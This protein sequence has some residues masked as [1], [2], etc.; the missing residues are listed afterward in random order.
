MSAIEQV[1]PRPAPAPS[2]SPFDTLA[3]DY[4]R[5]FT[6]SRIGSRMRQAVWPRLQARFR[7]GSRVLELNCGTGE[8]AVFLARNGVQVFA[9]DGSTAMAQA[10]QAKLERAGLTDLATAEALT[11]EQIVTRAELAEAEVQLSGLPFDGALSN[12]GGLN[13]VDDLTAVGAGLAACLRPGAVALVCIMGPLC[14]W[15]WIWYLRQGQPS[16]AFRRLRRDGVPWRGLTIRYPS[17]RAVRRAFAPHFRLLRAGAIGA[18]LPPTYA[19]E[20]AERHPRL[21]AHLDAWE[22]R[23]ETRWPLPWLADHFLLEFARLT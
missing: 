11:I 1:A 18:L 3:A 14:P 12:F 7:P 17:L 10:A 20:W 13:C 4:D 8:D 5:A 23:L 19:E 22:R 15:E 9:T 6:H 2:A 16:R 21:L